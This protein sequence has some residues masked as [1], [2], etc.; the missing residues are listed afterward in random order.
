MKSILSIPYILSKL[1]LPTQ[2][3]KNPQEGSPAAGS[4]QHEPIPGYSNSAECLAS[5]RV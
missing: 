5:A 1:K 2:I 4:C 3:A